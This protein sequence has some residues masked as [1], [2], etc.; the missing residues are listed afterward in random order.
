MDDGLIFKKKFDG[1]QYN[2]DERLKDPNFKVKFGNQEITMGELNN[3][4][5]STEK[6]VTL[7]I[8][9]ENMCQYFAFGLVSKL[10]EITGE[11]R[12]I[13]MKKFVRRE[14]YP[15]AI[16]YVKNVTFKDCKPE[17]I[18]K[19]IKKFYK[20][21]MEMSPITDFFA[22]MNMLRFM[23]DSVIFCFRYNVDFLDDFVDDIQK[24]KFND[25]IRCTK[26]V[27][28]NE[29]SIKNYLETTST[30]DIYV[31]ADMGIVYQTLMVKNKHN[32]TIMGYRDHN[33]I[34]DPV[35]AYYVNEFLQYNIPGPNN[36]I[37]SFLD[38]YKPTE[39][40]YKEWNDESKYSQLR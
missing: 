1:I 39:E 30:F 32:T 40:D 25:K 6:K 33:G 22:K 35:M 26:V 23:L 34:S 3:L 28:E 29:A 7:F 9:W 21:I 11:N 37:L 14:E 27:L 12:K 2:I 31:V 13:D 4:L 38:E 24:T 17:L 10:N 16:D 5:P 15:N 18:D 19:I 36:I 8:E 20:E